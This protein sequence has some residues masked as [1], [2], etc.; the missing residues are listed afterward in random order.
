MKIEYLFSVPKED[1]PVGP[2][3]LETPFKITPSENHPPLFSG[4]GGRVGWG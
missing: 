1:I 2:T 4:E 3:G